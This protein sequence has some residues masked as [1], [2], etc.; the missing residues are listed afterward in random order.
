LLPG[1]TTRAA[2]PHLIIN[3][4]DGRLTPLLL[5]EIIA[6]RGPDAIA[7]DELL[8]TSGPPSRTGA[9]SNHPRRRAARPE[10]AGLRTTGRK[11]LQMVAQSSGA[12][13]DAPWAWNS[14][15]L[16][17][18]P[19]DPSAAHDQ[20]QKIFKKC[21]PDHP[22]TVEILWQSWDDTAPAWYRIHI[23]EIYSIRD[24]PAMRGFWANPETG[25]I[26]LEDVVAVRPSIEGLPLS[27]TG[28]ASPK[29]RPSPLRLPAGPEDLLPEVMMTQA[30]AELMI[31]HYLHFESHR[32]GP[33]WTTIDTQ[34]AATRDRLMDIVTAAG[35]A[36]SRTDINITVAVRDTSVSQCRHRAFDPPPA[37][38]AAG[39]TRT[40]GLHEVAHAHRDGTVGLEEHGREH[41]DVALYGGS[42]PPG[43]CPLG[44]RGGAG[45]HRV[46]LPGPL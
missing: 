32:L 9:A 38:T 33:L 11:H 34:A 31:S 3:D 44:R 43:D 26:E 18:P 8:G 6:V 45:G 28:T 20:M 39:E 16:W 5:S 24:R 30:E 13:Y 10:V 42:L 12:D 4:D 21:S 22:E 41:L 19:E 36:G 14:F 23:M 1:G 46:P 37:Y 35:A 7:A 2:I 27:C 40:V 25:L 17:I 15:G 29:F